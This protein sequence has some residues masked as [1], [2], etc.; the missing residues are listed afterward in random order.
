MSWQA[1]VK[2]AV[3]SGLRGVQDV[4]N[5][6]RLM[7]PDVYDNQERQ[8][9]D[10]YKF[11]GKVMDPYYR[12]NPFKTWNLSANNKEGWDEL[13]RRCRYFYNRFW[14]YRVCYQS[15]WGFSPKAL[16]AHV[17]EVY[18]RINTAIAQGHKGRHELD[19]I[20][21]LVSPVLMDQL[22]A[23][24][25]RLQQAGRIVTWRM[26]KEPSASDVR[27]VNGFLA[28]AVTSGQLRATLHFVQWTV[29]VTS[30]Q[31]FAVH[32]KPPARSSGAPRLIAGDLDAP[33]RVVDHWVFERPVLK[34][35][36]VPKPGPARADWKLVA[37]LRQPEG[38]P[39]RLRQ[40][41]V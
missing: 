5:I 34:S 36:V 15:L 26:I 32:E 6:P 20:K 18:V 28:K 37:R 12:N 3:D 7:H 13:E 11:H 29:E 22:R 40:V 17:A 25:V 9:A 27:I 2:K 35:M 23:D 4:I 10:M 38:R 33:V 41:P 14:T 31:T 39:P 1:S 21:E 8:A 16:K 19:C 30:E 24:A